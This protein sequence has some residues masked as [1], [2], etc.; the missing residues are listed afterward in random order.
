[1]RARGGN[2]VSGEPP[3]G[4]P[5]ATRRIARNDLCTHTR[6][7][8]G[9]RH[10]RPLRRADR[11]PDRR[12]DRPCLRARALGSLRQARLRAARRPRARH[13]P[14]RPRALRAIPRRPAGRGRERARCRPGWHRDAVLPG[15]LAGVG[16]R[17][18]VHGLAQS[19]GLHRRK[20]RAR[21]R[22]R[23]VRRQRHPGHPPHDR[24]P[25]CPNPSAKARSSRSTSTRSSTRRCSSS[26]TRR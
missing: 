10:P 6:H 15:R 2:R 21:G 14:D 20:A 12:A 9:L 4:P 11:R 23:A 8:Q 3:I 26:S 17:P 18:D 22:D 13:A 25:V 5:Q 19:E 7:L 16:R 1:M 24:E